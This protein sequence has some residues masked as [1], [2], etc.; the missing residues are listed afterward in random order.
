M[1]SPA[2]PRGRPCAS[3]QLGWEGGPKECPVGGGGGG[4]RAGGRRRRWPSGRL[5][6]RTR[7]LGRSARGL[8]GQ[9]PSPWALIR[10][11]MRERHRRWSLAHSCRQALTGNQRSRHRG[12]SP[13]QRFTAVR[14]GTAAFAVQPMGRAAVG[15]TASFAWR[16]P[17][18]ACA[19]SC[20][21]VSRMLVQGA[22]S[23]KVIDSAMVL[24]SY[25]QMPA[26]AWRCRSGS[27]TDSP[28]GWCRGGV[29]TVARGG[30]R[31]AE[32]SLRPWGRC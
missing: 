19:I 23:T 30:P 18:I 26:R 1:C 32:S 28:A 15:H 16:G 6:D 12:H 17:R 25:R 3:R 14:D 13:I 8:P 7:G 10:Q 29:R 24:A 22:R 11:A 9:R 31:P 20:R 27:A 5:S 4:W 2:A 21:S